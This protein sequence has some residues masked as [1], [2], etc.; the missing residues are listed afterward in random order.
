MLLAVVAAACVAPP[1]QVLKSSDYKQVIARSL[2][3]QVNAKPKKSIAVTN[4]WMALT[5]EVM[6]CVR[7][8]IPDGRGGFHPEGYYSMYAIDKGK[9]VNVARDNADCRINQ[10]YAA[11]PPVDQ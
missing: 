6:V 7:E 5:G 8:D 1:D 2:G 9:I 3:H 11:L 4:P 10:T